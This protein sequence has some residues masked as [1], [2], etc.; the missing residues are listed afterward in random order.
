MLATPA[1]AAISQPTPPPPTH[2]S[3]NPSHR[4]GT[5]LENLALS[6]GASPQAVREAARTAQALAF[7]EALP[8]GF[9]TRLG[10]GAGGTQLSGGQLQRLGLARA[11]LRRPRLLLLDEP[12]SA[13]DSETERAVLAG[14]EAAMVGAEPGGAGRQVV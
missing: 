13:L 8:Q 10:G 2:P 5:I 7:I 3:P 11:L 14:L 4:S 6:I 1:A 12:T 9:A